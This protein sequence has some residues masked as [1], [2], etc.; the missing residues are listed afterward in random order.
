LKLLL[1]IKK[2]ITFTLCKVVQQQFIGEMGNLYLSDTKFL[3]NVMYQKFLKVVG[4]S[5]SC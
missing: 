2:K 4:V 1:N 3:Q 5:Q